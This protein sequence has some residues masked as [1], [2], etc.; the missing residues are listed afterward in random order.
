[1]SKLLH[2]Q[3]GFVL[4]AAALT[5][6]VVGGLAAFLFLVPARTVSGQVLDAETGEP[7]AG[8]VVRVEGRELSTATDGTFTASGVRFGSAVSVDARGYQPVSSV[9]GIAGQISFVV[10]P[11]VFEGYVVD[12]ATGMPVVGARLSA[13]S[14]AAGSDEQGRFRL[15]RLDP[16]T[17]VV[18]SATGFGREAVSYQDQIPAELRLKPNVLELRV[19]DQYSGQPVEGAEASSGGISARTGPQGQVRLDYLPEAAEVTVSASGYATGTARF[20]DANLVE[21]KLRPNVLTGLVKDSAGKPVAG[22]TVSDGSRT[23][24]TDGQGAFRLESVTE[25]FKLSV[26]ASGYERKL[27]EVTRQHT[28]EVALKPFAVKGLYL[29]YYGVG[30][31]GLRGH[32][33]D[34]AGKTEINAVVI[35]VK[36]DRGWISYKSSVPM[37][38]AIG[39]Q[40]DITM[41]KPKELLADLRKRGIYTIARIVTFKDNSLATARP[42]LAVINAATGRPWV[43]NEGLRWADPTRQEVWDYNTALAVEAIELGFDEVQFDYIRFPTDASAGNS[44]DAI[45]FSQANTME[46]R[47]AAINGFLERA[48]KAIKA[49][50]GNVSIDIFGYVVWRTDDMGIGQKLEEMA[51]YVDFISPMIYPNLFWDGI[52][53][54]DGV[55]YGG[56]K[57]GLYPYEI[58]NESMKIAVK[59]IGPAKLRPWLQYYSDYITGK[60]YT[61]AD[62]ELQ[63]R[64]TYDTGVDGWL[65][66]DPTNKF[67]RGGFLAE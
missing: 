58:V 32:V 46:N 31:E 34:L 55:K 42:D 23:A 67:A 52:P 2:T 44:L 29:T 19:I 54:D 47:M 10:P 49:K 25:T 24:T 39:A 37:V 48:S 50:G 38:Q 6:A 7:L 61:S 8:A 56:R 26:S 21:V 33:L 43:D 30:D 66:W 62:M 36:G 14:V 60:D 3:R 16:G 5:F 15:P 1:M 64:A 11:R 4:I 9:V 51:N 17:E 59:R 12:A 40:Q 35:D 63:K 27:V 13:G 18:V 20:Q 45:R 53:L 41:P 28:M 57:S 22:A 65:F